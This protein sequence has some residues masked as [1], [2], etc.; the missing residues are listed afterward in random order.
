MNDDYDVIG[1]QFHR[2]SKT[3][4][5]KVPRNHKTVIGDLCVVE[6]RGEYKLTT[7]VN[8]WPSLADRSRAT[9]WIVGNVDTTEYQKRALDEEIASLQK[10]LK[11]TTSRLVFL[12]AKR[13]MSIH[14]S[15]NPNE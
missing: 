3:Y 14:Y 9:A 1:V 10:K 7:V 13:G 11:D 5:Y 4:Y 8:T 6:V 15:Y 2:Y 12:Q